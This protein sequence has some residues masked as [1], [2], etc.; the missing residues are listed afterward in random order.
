MSFSKYIETSKQYKGVTCYLLDIERSADA[1]TRVDVKVMPTF[2]LYKNG[3]ERDEAVTKNK[4]MV[5]L[6]ELRAW[7]RCLLF[8]VRPGAVWEWGFY[9]DMGS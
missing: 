4:C 9:V 2:K 5:C 3:L 1:A 6:S 8:R 7:D